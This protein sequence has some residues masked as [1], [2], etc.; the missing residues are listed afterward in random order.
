MEGTQGYRIMM[1]IR[2]LVSLRVQ[3][4]HGGLIISVLERGSTVSIKNA[5]DDNRPDLNIRGRGM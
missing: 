5:P 3:E 1:G 2:C 4:G